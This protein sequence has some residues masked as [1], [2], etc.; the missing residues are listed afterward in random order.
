MG[1]FT[2]RFGSSI[3]LEPE[4]IPFFESTNWVVPETGYYNILV[5]GCGGGCGFGVDLNGSD[6]P[7]AGGGGAGGLAIKY[8]QYLEA[9]QT[10]TITLGA[11]GTATVTGGDTSFVL[12]AAS[13]NMVAQSGRN[14]TAST[15][16]TPRNIGGVGGLASGGDYN[17][18]GGR[19]GNVNRVLTDPT[20]SGTG[21][22]GGVNFYGRDTHGGDITETNITLVP[23]MAGTGGG[24][25]GNGMDNLT[26]DTYTIDP[27]L[28]N[29]RE[30]KAGGSYDFYAL[31]WPTTPFR[32]TGRGATDTS[33]AEDGGGGCF[34][35]SAGGGLGGYGGGGGTGGR[36]GLGGGSS[37]MATD[38]NSPTYGGAA[39]VCVQRVK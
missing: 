17:G 19:G 1:A 31:P 10:A 11:T 14:S 3:N 8:N 5:M 6:A 16:N 4:Y 33:P 35:G 28:V 21:G 37:I 24:T 15:V 38:A 22:G 18:Q 27:E 2:D 30:A 39:F 26:L 7:Y 29:Q 34:A 20:T 32:P 23:H 12:A 36:G 25:G 13:I 9:G